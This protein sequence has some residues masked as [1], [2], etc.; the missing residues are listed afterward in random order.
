MMR[1]RVY[2]SIF[3]FFFLSSC[4]RSFDPIEA[5]AGLNGRWQES[6][7]AW[8]PSAVKIPEDTT[9][10]GKVNRVT[11]LDFTGDRY[12]VETLPHLCS[13]FGAY[14]S[15]STGTYRIKEDTIV[16]TIEPE[17][18]VHKRLFKLQKDELVLWTLSTRINDSPYLAASGSFIWSNSMGKTGGKFRRAN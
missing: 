5:N 4:E 6:F 15:L 17:S 3:L 8:N 1:K 16:F 13:G 2:I 11:T 14:D 18:S 10:T 12:A 7:E 9:A